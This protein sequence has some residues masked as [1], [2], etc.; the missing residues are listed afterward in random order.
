MEGSGVR[1]EKLRTAALDCGS[2]QGEWRRRGCVCT[3]TVQ[4]T[5]RGGENERA[6]SCHQ[7]ALVRLGDVSGCGASSMVLGHPRPDPWQRALSGGAPACERCVHRWACMPCSRQRT[8]WSPGK[9]GPSLG[10]CVTTPNLSCRSDL[11]A[12]L[13]TSTCRASLYVSLWQYSWDDGN[14]SMTAV[15]L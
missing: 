9:L 10:L 14:L 1:C 13:H 2:G 4:C 6:G 11:A 7:A 8:S 3:A 5:R 15:W 12:S